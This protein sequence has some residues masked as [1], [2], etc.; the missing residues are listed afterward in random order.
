MDDAAN[1]LP[2]ALPGLERAHRVEMMITAVDM[3]VKPAM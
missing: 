1:L 3:A 2:K